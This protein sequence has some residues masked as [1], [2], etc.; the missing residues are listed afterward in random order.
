MKK[1][2]VGM[3]I[4]VTPMTAYHLRQMAKSDREDVGRIIDK[5]VRDRMVLLRQAM[6][7]EV[8]RK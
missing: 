8:G 5:L 1:R 7:T 4:K 3:S 6:R 2:L